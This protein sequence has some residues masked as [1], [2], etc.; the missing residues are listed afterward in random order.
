MRATRPETLLGDDER[1]GGAVVD[2][3]GHRAPNRHTAQCA[4]I[5]TQ[6]RPSVCTPIGGQPQ[7]GKSKDAT[8][9]GQREPSGQADLFGEFRCSEMPTSTAISWGQS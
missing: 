3:P 5:P 6:L 2:E 7:T 9:Q 8:S 4:F 1:A